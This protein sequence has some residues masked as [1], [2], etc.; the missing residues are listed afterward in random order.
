ME[1][2]FFL[3]AGVRVLRNTSPRADGG[4]VPVG[5]DERYREV[6]GRYR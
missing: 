2:L 3:V 6:R 1:P 4:P 5:G